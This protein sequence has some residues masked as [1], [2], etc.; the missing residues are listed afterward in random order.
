MVFYVFYLQINVFNIYGL[1]R[2]V[3]KSTG[4]GTFWGAVMQKPLNR[5]THNLAEM[6]TSGRP[7]NTPNG[8]SIGSGA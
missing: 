1:V 8:I 2:V 3:R 7:L 6:I 5:S 4:N